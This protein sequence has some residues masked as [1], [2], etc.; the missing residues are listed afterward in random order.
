MATG[1]HDLCLLVRY[2]LG[3]GLLKL[4][5]LDLDCGWNEEE[6]EHKLEKSHLHYIESF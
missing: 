3:T 6:V 4:D 1:D 2:Y 5:A